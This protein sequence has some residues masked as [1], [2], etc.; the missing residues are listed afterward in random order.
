MDEP[1]KAPGSST[2]GTRTGRI[3]RAVSES[4]S[5]LWLPH[6]GHERPSGDD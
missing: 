4:I 6:G 2:G 3:G 5:A 1:E